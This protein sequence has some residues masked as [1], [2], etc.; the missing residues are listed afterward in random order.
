MRPGSASR[1]AAAVAAKD[2]WPSGKP[3]ELASP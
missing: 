3:S 2:A 1:S